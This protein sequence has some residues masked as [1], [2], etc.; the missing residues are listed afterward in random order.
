MPWKIISKRG[1]TNQWIRLDHELALTWDQSLKQD[2]Y[3]CIVKLVQTDFSYGY[4]YVHNDEICSGEVVMGIQNI[5]DICQS[6][7]I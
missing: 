7:S 5:C 4:E 1:Q 6:R 2:E 3:N